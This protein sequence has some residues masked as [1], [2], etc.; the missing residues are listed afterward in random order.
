MIVKGTMNIVDAQHIDVIQSNIQYPN[1]LCLDFDEQDDMLHLCFKNK[2]EKAI[3]LNPPPVAMHAYIDGNYQEFAPKNYI[4]P[5]YFFDSATYKKEGGYTIHH[6]VGS[7]SKPKWLILC[8]LRP[9]VKLLRFYVKPFGAWYQERVNKKMV[10]RSGRF[11]E[12][13]KKNNT[14]I[15]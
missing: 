3:M 14:G 9:Y 13:Y 1:T 6:G 12:I 7:W 15:I 8:W 10:A 2:C 5:R 11:L 4:Y